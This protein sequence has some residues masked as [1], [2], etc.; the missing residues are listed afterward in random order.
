MPFVDIW[1]VAGKL[2]SAVVEDEAKLL[3]EIALKVLEPGDLVVEIGS[4]YGRSSLILGQAAKDKKAL[5]VCIDCFIGPPGAY[6]T[7][8]RAAFDQTMNIYKMPHLLYPMRSE[9]VYNLINYPIKVLFIDGDHS[10][11]GVRQDCDNYIPKV[12]GIIAFHDYYTKCPQVQMGVDEAVAKYG[13]ALVK[14]T[15]GMIV[16]KKRTCDA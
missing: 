6:R 8:L 15:L 3:Y 9:N 4:E 14:Q 2:I 12:N 7:Q 13:L 10:I 1:K 16:Y 5:L 11:E